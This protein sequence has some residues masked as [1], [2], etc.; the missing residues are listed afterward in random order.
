MIRLF[1]FGENFGLADPS[2]FVLKVDAYLRMSGIN[3]D[4]S[5]DFSDF[6]KAPKGKLPYIK[7]GDCVVA[8]SFFILEYLKEKYPAPLE[9]GITEAQKAISQLITKSLD[10]NFY[11]CIVYSRWVREDTW[12]TIR[13]AFFG[14]LP[15]PLKHMIPFV[16]RK[17]VKSA[18]AK[19]GI[20]KHSDEEIMRIAENTLA[21]LSVLL[22]DK[23]YF[24][25]E[26]PSTLD[27]VVYGFVAQVTLVDLENPLI[28]RA[29]KHQNLVAFC[30]RI[31]ATYYS[32][33]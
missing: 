11:W 27:A 16:A 6:K 23:P 17:G 1:G 33:R 12:P 3:F 24:F 19:H 31:Q 29:R 26:S 20:G 18:L 4:T 15:F 9:E 7:D 2:P 10:E 22:A 13:D 25:G 21:N 32:T 8:D 5:S 28:K 14:S 30:H